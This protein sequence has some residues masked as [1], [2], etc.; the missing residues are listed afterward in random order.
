[1]KGGRSL[2]TLL[3]LALLTQLSHEFLDSQ[4]IKSRVRRCARQFNIAMTFQCR[5]MTEESCEPIRQM[6]ELE[7]PLE[8][9]DRERLIARKCCERRCS[10]QV[11]RSF[12][13]LV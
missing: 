3:V 2:V 11:L 13:C 12:C 10:I 6:F 8:P 1:M 4:V 7:G 9:E 5:S